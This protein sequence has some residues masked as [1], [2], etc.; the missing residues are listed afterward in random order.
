[1]RKFINFVFKNQYVYQYFYLIYTAAQL[2]WLILL[3]ISLIRIIPSD[4]ENGNYTNT[5]I[6]AVF[7]F[8]GMALLA[9]L[10]GYIRKID[11]FNPIISTIILFFMSPFRFFFQIATIVLMHI[12]SSN[13]IKDYAKML[14]SG[15]MDSQF[16]SYSLFNCLLANPT[17]G[18]V[19]VSKKQREKKERGDKIINDYFD[20]VEK[21]YS[22][23]SK[24]LNNYKRSDGKHNVYIIPSASIGKTPLRSFSR[25]NNYSSYKSRYIDRVYIN[26]Y[27]MVDV[28]LYENGLCFS[29]E[30]GT[31]TFKVHVTGE[32][33]PFLDEKNKRVVD[34][35]FTLKNIYVGDNNVY[36]LISMQFDEVYENT[37]N[38]YTRKVLERRFKKF[39][40]H[41]S[42]KQV[43][44]NM[45]RSLDDREDNGLVLSLCIPINQV[46]WEGGWAKP[47]STGPDRL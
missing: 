5:I 10:D 26:G 43:N 1:M 39:D 47:G 33:Q 15:P 44:E 25:L 24:M 14:E 19:F 18:K 31:Y 32:V 27:K 42:F 28:G 38:K 40:S 21:E 12:A 6:I 8:I 9:C 11:N 29:L 22:T 41:F 46:A 7:M 34:H 30:P 3:G 20:K 17:S 2:F 35:T 16:L 36:L 23:A 13:G 37:I 4:I 45:I